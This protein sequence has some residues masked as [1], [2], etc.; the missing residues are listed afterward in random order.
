VVSLGVYAQDQNDP[1]NV[2]DIV[3]GEYLVEGVDVLEADVNLDC[4]VDGA[5]LV[6]FAI[7]FGT[8]RS[9]ARYDA[10]YDFNTDGVID[11]EDL[12][13]VANQFGQSAG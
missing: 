8:E 2:L 1:P 11:G 4:R 7:H 3:L 5:D 12:A 13:V 10:L 6:D 9:Q